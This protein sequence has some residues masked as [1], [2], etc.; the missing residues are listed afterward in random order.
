MRRL[1]VRMPVL[2]QTHT[3]T[4]LGYR[5][6]ANLHVSDDPE[7]PKTPAAHSLGP[8]PPEG[9]AG[10][11]GHDLAQ[12]QHARTVELT[13]TPYCR[14]RN[15]SSY[16][17]ETPERL[18]KIPRPLPLFPRGLR[19]LP[20]TGR[21]VL[22]DG[23]YRQPRLHSDVQDR[24]RKQLPPFT[25]PGGGLPAWDPLATSRSARRYFDK[26]YRIRRHR[27]RTLAAHAAGWMR[28]AMTMAQPPPPR[29]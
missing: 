3:Q 24:S 17:V 9:C 6:C 27:G 21:F 18:R 28:C 2:D 5:L 22:G 16:S 10:S 14:M 11:R 12:H 4:A 19:I 29:T 26:R 7:T 25:P 1:I 20:R 8:L 23:P 15:A 13:L